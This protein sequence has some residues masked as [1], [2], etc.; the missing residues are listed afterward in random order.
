M[1]ARQSGWSVVQGGLCGRLATHSSCGF[2]VNKWSP[3]NATRRDVAA[4]IFGVVRGQLRAVLALEE[5]DEGPERPGHVPAAPIADLQIEYSL[6]SRGIED[7]ILPACRELGIGSPAYGVLSRGLIS[8]NWSKERQGDQDFRASARAS[9]AIISTAT[10]PWSKRCALW[11]RQ[12]AYRSP[13][14]PSPGWRRRARNIV[15]L[16]GARRRDR[17][18]EALGALEV[19]RDAADLLAISRA[20]PKGAAAGERYA[21]AQMAMLDSEKA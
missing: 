14:S 8:G 7:G 2:R 5:I 9:R 12:R 3:A 6:I 19:R 16:V 10:S 21:A 17:L 15:P 20:V 18:S 1:V 11:L 13:R 4:A